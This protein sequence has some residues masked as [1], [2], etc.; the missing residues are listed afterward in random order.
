MSGEPSRLMSV[1]KFVFEIYFPPSLRQ[2]KAF[3]IGQPEIGVKFRL[4]LKDPDQLGRRQFQ[5]FDPP[6]IRG[7]DGY[8]RPFGLGFSRPFYEFRR[9]RV[10]PTDP[11]GL[12]EIRQRLRQHGVL[13]GEGFYLIIKLIIIF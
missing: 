4:A 13:M 9:D 2:F 3:L 8:R 1:L 12:V 6:P 7:G 10:L 5:D 11:G